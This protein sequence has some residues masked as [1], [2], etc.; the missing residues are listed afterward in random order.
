MTPKQVH[1]LYDGL[2]PQEQAD[3]V[4]AAIARRDSAEA[5]TIH[6]RVEQV[7]YRTEH[8]DYHQRL[9]CLQSLAFIYGVEYWKL[10]ALMLV[11][12]IEDGDTLKDR[13]ASRERFLQKTLALEV[14]L[15]E[16]C[17]RF[18][19]DMAAIKTLAQCPDAEADKQ[20]LPADAADTELVG[21]Y[22]AMLATLLE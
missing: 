21:E 2:T 3:M 17:G 5:D 1:R 12:K 8:V 6:G 9:L 14:A 18:K 22:D 10:R 13:R 4:F 20:P 15:I 19:I 7:V 16:V 11:C